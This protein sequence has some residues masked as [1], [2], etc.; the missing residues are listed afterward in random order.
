M[1][2]AFL[3]LFLGLKGFLGLENFSIKPVKV[4][5]EQGWLAPLS[6]RENVEMTLH[7]VR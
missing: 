6:R 5:A 1:M 7:V 2:V 4:P 3:L